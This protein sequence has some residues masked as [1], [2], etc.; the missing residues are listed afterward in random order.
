MAMAALPPGTRPG[1]HD[2]G[3]PGRGHRLPGLGLGELWR[4]RPGSGLNSVMSARVE[5]S[6]IMHADDPDGQRSGLRY[7][8]KPSP[9]ATIHVA[10]SLITRP[11]PGQPLQFTEGNRT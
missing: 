2:R 7:Q 3:T 4:V 1:D 10:L 5:G 11:E 9:D 8:L 6:V